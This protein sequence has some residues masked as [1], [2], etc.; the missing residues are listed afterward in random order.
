MPDRRQRQLV[1]TLLE[2]FLELTESDRRHHELRR[3][4]TGLLKGD[5]AGLPLEA[6]SELVLLLLFYGTHLGAREIAGL[7]VT[8]VTPA[9]MGRFQ[10]RTGSDRTERS[11]VLPSEISEA[12]RIYLGKLHKS[13]GPLLPHPSGRALYETEVYDIVQRTSNESLLA[14]FAKTGTVFLGQHVVLPTPARMRAHTGYAGRGVTIAFVDSGFFAHPD[15]VRPA[16]R[17]RAYVDITGRGARLDR[18]SDDAW[19]GTMTSVAC[20]GNGWLSGGLYPGIASEASLVLVA[21]GSKV[22]PG[23]VTRAIEWVVEHREEHDIRI[24]NISLGSSLALSYRESPIDAA[25]ELAVQAGI[26]VVAA[27]GND[28]LRV[29]SPPANS[30]SV[31]TV[32]GLVDKNLPFEMTYSPYSSP[33]GATVDGILKPEITAPSVLVAAPILPGSKEFERARALWYQKSLP[34]DELLAEVVSRRQLLGLPAGWESRD[35]PALRALL[36]GETRRMKLV[37]AHYQHVDGTSFAAPIVTSIVAQMLEANPDLGPRDVREILIGTAQTA[38]HIP[39]ER[40]GYGVVQALAAVQAAEGR[41]PHQTATAGGSPRVVGNDVTF[42]WEGDGLSSVAVAGDFNG[43]RGRPLTRREDGV[44]EGTVRLALPGT[45]RYK[46]V[47]DGRYW[48]EDDGNHRSEPDGYGHVNSV[49]EI[50]D[51]MPEGGSLDEVFAHRHPPVPGVQGDSAL[52]ALDLF[53]CLPGA[54]RNRAV[55]EYWLKCLDYVTQAL[56]RPAR[57]PLEIW[58]LYNCGIVVRTPSFSLGIDVVT[59]RHVWGVAWQIPEDLVRRLAGSLDGL[60]VTQRLPDHLDLDVVRPLIRSGR[61]VVVPK[62]VRAVIA[63][64][65]LGMAAG[66]T[67]ELTLGGARVEVSAHRALHA[68]DRAGAVVQR[69]Y[70]VTFD[71]FTVLHLAD[72][73]HTRFLDLRKAPDVVFAKLGRF[74]EDDDPAASIVRLS[75]RCRPGTLIPTHLAELGDPG[76]GG[77]EGYDAAKELLDAAAVPSRLLAWGESWR[78]PAGL[79]PCFASKPGCA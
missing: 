5:A 36:D 41:S 62:E 37:A 61:P 70:E 48:V 35:A 71:G 69:S 52:T 39:R 28:P 11:F 8:R 68:R 47:L 7:D 19:H 54:A 16:N 49:F 9:E 53:V 10:I 22:D 24:L 34:D 40:Q 32:G 66:T 45:Y 13:T 26:F 14:P 56:A 2:R 77:L 25:A 50:A 65:A 4:I 57:A 55:A 29:S 75:E 79:V 51:F 27:A 46:F 42:Q 31:L 15:L 3:Q 43:W 59:G 78:A 44:W 58:Q 23:D 63:E 18:S 74:G 64:Q 12:L 72:H 67:R 73:D 6:L 20:A 33:S 1:Q 30:P 38:P 76:H 17:I 21:V 60:L